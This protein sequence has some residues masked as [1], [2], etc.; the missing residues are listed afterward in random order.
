LTHNVLFPA[1]A[2][3]EERDK[4]YFLVLAHSITNPTKVLTATQTLVDDLNNGKA[5]LIL[6]GRLEYT[7]IFGVPHWVTLCVPSGAYPTS[8]AALLTKCF[9]QNNTTDRSQ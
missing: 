4:Y 3:P 5:T 8:D 6:H 1:A 7:D 9:E 2:F